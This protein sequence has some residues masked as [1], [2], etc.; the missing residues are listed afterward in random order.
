MIKEIRN[1]ELQMDL[2][3]PTVLIYLSSVTITQLLIHLITECLQ[4]YM[5]IMSHRFHSSQKLQTHYQTT[6][7]N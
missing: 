4:S 2:E 6:I 5:M 1:L 3:V 7:L